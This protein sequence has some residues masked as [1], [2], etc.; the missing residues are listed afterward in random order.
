MSTSTPLPKDWR[1]RRRLRP[2][3]LYEQRW[4]QK[5]IAAAIGVTEGAVGQWISR[6][7]M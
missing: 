7:K 3:E 5:A 2:W 1:E 4:K 6:A